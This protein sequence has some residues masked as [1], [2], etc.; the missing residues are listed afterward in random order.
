MSQWTYPHTID[1]GHGEQLTFVRREKGPDG[2]RLIVTN[3]VGPGSGPPMHVHFR[4]REGLTVLEGR[5]AYQK[6]G[7]EVKYAGPGDS[8]DF[9]AGEA[10]RFWNAG[11]GVMRCEGYIMP[12][13]NIEYFL[14]KIYESAR[15]NGGGRPGT[16][17]SAFLLDRYRSEFDMLVIPPLVKKV[18]FP[19][20]LLMG[21]LTGKAKKYA[22]APVPVGG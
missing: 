4:Q 14:T 10:H 17:D 12:P 8:V 22:D 13:D 9:A 1:N 6:P 2:E 11:E 7:E 20:A 15:E 19:I 21:K 3:N 18:I 16:F 5:L